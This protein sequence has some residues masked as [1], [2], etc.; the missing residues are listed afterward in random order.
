MEVELK[1]RL[2][3]IQQRFGREEKP[4]ETPEIMKGTGKLSVDVQQEVGQEVE[5]PQVEEEE[6]YEEVEGD[7]NLAENEGFVGMMGLFRNK[8]KKRVRRTQKKR[9]EVTGNAKQAKA[10]KL[11]PV[12]I[13]APSNDSGFEIKVVHGQLDALIAHQEREVEG[14]YN[15]QAKAAPEIENS[16][17][18]EGKEKEQEPA[19]LPAVLGGFVQE[20]KEEDPD[21]RPILPALLAGAVP[22][23]LVDNVAATEEVQ[24]AEEGQGAGEA[25]GDALQGLVGSEEVDEQKEVEPEALVETKIRDTGVDLEDEE[26]Q[27]HEAR[28]GDEAE[29]PDVGEALADALQGLVGSEEVNE[30]KEVGLEAVENAKS[31]DIDFDLKGQE[32]QVPDAEE[33]DDAEAQG[34]GEALAEALQGLANPENVDEEKEPEPEALEEAQYGDD[35][36][37]E[38]RNNAKLAEDDDYVNDA[39]VDQGQ[40]EVVFAK[41]SGNAIVTEEATPE[42]EDRRLDE[43]PASEEVP[44]AEEAAVPE[45]SMTKDEAV[46][47][48]E[49]N[50]A[51]EANIAEEYAM[52]DQLP[53]PEEDANDGQA[54]LPDGNVR[55]DGDQ[56]FSDNVE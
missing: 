16:R 23:D 18:N 5:P 40:N 19:V 9:V 49:T 50:E 28:T 24:G 26:K 11:K 39:L 33:G 36:G 27:I 2:A 54:P 12:E 22:D 13:E 38:A 51:E 48:E 30:Q 1:Q 55:E 46:E 44:V 56:M 47:P 14:E 52:I 4:S 6:A 34:A 7:E 35:V 21:E 53:L 32:E 8:P 25:L 29:T 41:E 10:E 15:V 37:A 31:R 17:P 3:S 20:K 43:A 42:L 45:E